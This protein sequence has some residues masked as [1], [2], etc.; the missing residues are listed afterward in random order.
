A[1]TNITTGVSTAVGF[2]VGVFT[3]FR[4]T[5]LG[6]WDTIW[7]GIKFVINSITGG[8]NVM[9]RGLNMLKIDIPEWVPYLGGQT[10]GISIPEIPKLAEGGIVTEPTIAMIGE[11]GPEA[12]VP[13]DGGSNF[14][15]GISITIEN[16]SVRNDQD[17][18]LIAQE[19][20]TMIERKNRGRGVTY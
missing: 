6:I 3:S 13:L 5:I 10:F 15:G 20:A 19:L 2:I 1:W 9:I 11:A 7:T 8:I 14:G 4:D 18:K 16:L 12:I 17:I